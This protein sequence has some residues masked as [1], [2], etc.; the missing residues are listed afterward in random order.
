M[1]LY[2]LGSGGI[3]SLGIDDYLFNGSGICVI[4]WADKIKTKIPG[5]WEIN[6]AWLSEN[7]RKFKITRYK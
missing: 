6:I 1:D 5:A 2:R 3:N 4:E 7:K